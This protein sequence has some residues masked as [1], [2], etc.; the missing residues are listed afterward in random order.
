LIVVDNGSSDGTREYLIE[1]AKKH[2][3]VRLILNDK[4]KGYAGGNN[5]GIK[6]S[7]GEFIVLLN[8]D[9]LVTPNWIP[10]LI[11][12][13]LSDPLIGMV[14]PITN[15][16]GSEQRVSIEKINSRNYIK[17]AS[18]Y[19]NHHNNI[20]LESHRLG[21][22]C[23]VIKR[24][25][26][27]KIGFL[28]TDYGIGMFEDD[29]FCSRAIKSGFKL[30]FVENCF[31][32]HKGSLSFEKIGGRERRK[33]FEKNKDIFYK[34]NKIVWTHANQGLAH[35][36][37]FRN[38]TKNKKLINPFLI[39]KRLDNLE[40]L[41]IQWRNDEIF[42]KYHPFYKIPIYKIP[43]LNEFVKFVILG[44]AESRK[45]YFERFKKFIKRELKL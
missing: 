14:G 17:L 11:Q 22:F 23:V 40:R 4:N 45:I 41:F 2:K 6:N 37:L 27:K 8:N 39:E 31:I 29:D 20:W 18:E 36:N 19:T 9:T 28:D 32:Y 44:D 5:D 34:K 43:R 38:L 13:F 3:N 33:L 25:V 15:N 10:K 12:P 24:L 21:F 42:S 30:I 1:F 7:S 35:I 16:A 26:I